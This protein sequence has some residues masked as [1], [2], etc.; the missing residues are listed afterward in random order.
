[1]KFLRFLSFAI[2]VLMQS[3]SSGPPR[4]QMQSVL[5][6]CDRG[7]SFD[8]YVNC[9]KYTYQTQGTQPNASGVRSFISNLDMLSE[10]YTNKQISQAQAKAYAYDYYMRTIHAENARSKAASDAAFMNLMQIQQQQ[11]I[12]QQQRT[13]IQTNCVRNGQFTNCTSY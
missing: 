4:K 5:N 1:M 3:C 7:Q 12:L 13:P 11:Q 10:A 8:L 6:E 9:V 2:L